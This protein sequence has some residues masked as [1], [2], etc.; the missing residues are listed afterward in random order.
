MAILKDIEKGAGEI[1]RVEVS[2]YQGKKYLNVR[3]WY[4][5]K[6]SGEFKPTQKGVA[7]RPDQFDEF[8]SAINAARAE[9]Q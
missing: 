3:V 7:I 8:L 1:I 4:T 2:E 5:D 6:T 9:L